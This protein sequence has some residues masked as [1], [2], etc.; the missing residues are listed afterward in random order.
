M[1][2]NTQHKTRLPPFWATTPNPDVRK[3]MSRRRRRISFRWRIQL[4]GRCRSRYG[5]IPKAAAN[6][7][8]LMSEILRKARSTPLR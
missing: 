5:S 4:P 7:V 2:H 1:I 6:L 3:R 8:M